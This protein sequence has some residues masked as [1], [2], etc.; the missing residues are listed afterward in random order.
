MGIYQ[1]SL[2]PIEDRV[3][4]YIAGMTDK[5]ILNVFYSIFIPKP[6]EKL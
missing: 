4:D 6:W 5:Y 1:N 2:N 3:C